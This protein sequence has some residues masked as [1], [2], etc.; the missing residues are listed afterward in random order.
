MTAPAISAPAPKDR[1]GNGQ[2]RRQASPSATRPTPRPPPQPPPSPRRHPRRPRA[3]PPRR[4]LPPRRPR[5]ARS[6]AQAGRST[7]HAYSPAWPM[8][9]RR[10]RCAPRESPPSCRAARHGQDQPGR[11]GL[12]RPDHGGRGRR[13]HGGRLRRRVDPA[14]GRHL[15][16]HF[17]ETLSYRRPGPL[18]EPRTDE[19]SRARLS[20]STSGPREA[21]PSARPACSSGPDSPQ[22]SGRS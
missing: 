5:P 16:V 12:P 18:A 11:G 1:L 4:R 14:A 9:R 8:S 7:G 22:R 15:R 2:L 13:Q 19:P 6:H 10:A 21:A 17:M 20:A 3:P